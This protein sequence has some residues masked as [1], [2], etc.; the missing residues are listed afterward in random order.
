[1]NSFH[2]AYSELPPARPLWPVFLGAFVVGFV[3][4]VLSLLLMNSLPQKPRQGAT[5][6]CPCVATVA[7]VAKPTA[8]PSC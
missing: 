2:T 7:T 1:M 3:L 4:S 8:P 6:Q 5:Q